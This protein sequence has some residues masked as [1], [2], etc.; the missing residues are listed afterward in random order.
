MLKLAHSFKET[1]QQWEKIDKS[2]KKLWF[3]NDK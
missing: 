3:G 2:G 1:N